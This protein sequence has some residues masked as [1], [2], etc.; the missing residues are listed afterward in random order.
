MTDSRNER[1]ESLFHGTYR[2]LVQLKNYFIIFFNS[3]HFVS[4]HLGSIRFVLFC[5][6]WGCNVIAD[7]RFFCL[8]FRNTYI[9]KLLK[10]LLAAVLQADCAIIRSANQQEEQRTE[11]KRRAGKR[12]GEAT[13]TFAQLT[14]GQAPPPGQPSGLCRARGQLLCGGNCRFAAAILVDGKS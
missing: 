11:D 10:R 1:L 6:N 9:I 13:E 14:L 3:P 2:L 7:L 5:S 12:R 8:F 4:F